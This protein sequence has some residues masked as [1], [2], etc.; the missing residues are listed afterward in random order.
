MRAAVPPARNPE[1]FYG[2]QIKDRE[3]IKKKIKD[4][5]K[6]NKRDPI[7]ATVYTPTHI[8]IYFF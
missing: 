1:L 4:R 6:Q 5:E 8:Y 2:K 7:E 3:L